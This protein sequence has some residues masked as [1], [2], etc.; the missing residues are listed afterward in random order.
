MVKRRS[1]L[2]TIVTKLGDMSDKIKWFGIYLGCKC[3]IQGESAFPKIKGLDSD[4]VADWVYF[5]NIENPQLL[6][7]C[8]LILKELES[9]SDEDL[10]SVGEIYG[11]SSRIDKIRYLKGWNTELNTALKLILE[12]DLLRS[13][14]YAVGIP[15]EYYITELEL[16]LK[17]DG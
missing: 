15:K 17:S 9:I 14:G 5:E 10:D 3:A 1:K 11:C 7:D 6:D 16:K 4:N 2:F 8:V 13:M 12:V